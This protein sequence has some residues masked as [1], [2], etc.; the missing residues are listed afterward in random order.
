[1]L[2]SPLMLQIPPSM[3]MTDEHFFEFCQVNRDLALSGT[4]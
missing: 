2:S 4:D 1:M 3:Q